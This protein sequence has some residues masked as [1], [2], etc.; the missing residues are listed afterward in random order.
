MN[1]LK[2]T[3]GIKIL[4]TVMCTILGALFTLCFLR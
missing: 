4:L 2:P 3:L 1:E